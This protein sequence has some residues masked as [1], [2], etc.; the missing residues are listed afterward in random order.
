MAATLAVCLLLTAC[1]ADPMPRAAG[2][3]AVT[4]T[5][6][7]AAS[8]VKKRP[9]R[10]G[11]LATPVRA[12]DRRIRIKHATLTSQSGASYVYVTGTDTVTASPPADITDDNIREV[13]WRADAVR[14]ADQQTCS[15]WSQTGGSIIG[16]PIQPGLALRIAPAGPNNPGLRAI[17]VTENVVYDGVWVFNVH[18]WDTSRPV[19]MTL[20]ESFDASNIVGR[21]VN[22]DGRA[23][24]LIARPPWHVCARA[25]GSLFSFKI[26]I[27]TAA[28]PSWSDPNHAFHVLLPPGWDYSGYAGDYIGHLHPGQSSTATAE[29]P[30]TLD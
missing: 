24:S 10:S 22:T 16:A 14:S 30:T 4:S 17:T 27:G 19:P 12:G 8:G 3:E 13:F 1:G 11:R 6:S 15:S 2:S 23:V 29:V 28:E 7:T 9:N 20:L 25:Q 21:I 5:P 26:W 18:V